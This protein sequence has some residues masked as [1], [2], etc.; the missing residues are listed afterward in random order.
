MDSLFP[1][2]DRRRVAVG[3]VEINCR[4][5]GRGPAILLL[6]GYP[7]THAC[8][9][10][11]APK[12]AGS[13]SV[14]LPDLPG[15][16]DSA[17]IEPDPENRNYSKRRTAATMAG[18]MQELGW[19]RFAVVGHDR[20]ARVAYRLALDRADCVER[21]ALF[22]ILP[23]IE[24][25]AIFDRSEAMA[26]FHWPFLAQEGGLP[27]TLIAREPDFFLRYLMS[28]WAGDLTRIDPEALAD[29]LRCFRDPATIHGICEDY[30]AAA[31]IDLEHDRADAGR[32]KI[33]CPVLALWGGRG[34]LDKWYDVL[35][36]W[37][38]WAD[39]VRGRSLAC[40]HYLPEEAPE[41]TAAELGAF[42]TA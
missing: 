26:T 38:E 33:A 12:L 4:T 20:G 30:R 15:Y 9:H 23:T 19:S 14:V 35:A 28:R 16:G 5:A 24:E 31:S 40:G 1:G 34:K 18:L 36:V 37:R 3:G 10:R 11:V 27:E 21:L 41:E 17:F 7:E 8:W 42:F 29:Y 22:D 6:H 39:D 2:F 25:W 13:F 32:R